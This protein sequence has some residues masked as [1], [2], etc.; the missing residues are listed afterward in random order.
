MRY[1][2]VKPS[3]IDARLRTKSMRWF[4]KSRCKWCMFWIAVKVSKTNVYSTIFA[5]FGK[6]HGKLLNQTS[7]VGRCNFTRRSATIFSNFFMPPNRHLLAVVFCN[8]GLCSIYVM[9]VRVHHGNNR[10]LRHLS[11]L[12]NCFVHFFNRLTGIN[13]NNAFGGINKRLV[14]QPITHKAPHTGANFAERAL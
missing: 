14:R 7:A 2:N 13:G 1:F 4:N 10:A 9:E 8:N 12:C 3:N 5:I 6:L 11:Q